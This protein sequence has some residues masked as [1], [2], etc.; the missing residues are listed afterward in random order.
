MSI[1]KEILN[2][3]I[4]VEKIHYDDRGLVPAVVQDY[5]DGTILMMAWMNRESLQKTMETGETWFWS[6]SR[7][8]LWHKGA[9]S[10]H[11]Q[12][13]RS[14][15]YDCDSDA[16]LVSVEQVG[17]V[18]CHTGERSCFHRM[19]GQ[20]VPPPADTLSQLFAVICDRRDYPMEDSYTCKLLANGDNKILKKL[21]EET[22]EV[23]MACKDDDSDAIASEVADLLYHTLVALAHHKVELKDVYRQLQKRRR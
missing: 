5:L 19:D 16:L 14:L 17:D 10:G 18:A 3:A 20:V 4:P 8:E 2:E 11:I 13:V 15:R 7:A 6:R 12:K 21:G 9:T 22:A 23:V 1:D